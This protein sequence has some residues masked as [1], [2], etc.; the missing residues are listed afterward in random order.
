MAR[1]FGSLGRWG[2]AVAGLLGLGLVGPWAQT[3]QELFPLAVGNRWEYRGMLTQMPEMPTAGLQP[4]GTP[5]GWGPPAFLTLQW[6]GTMVIEVVRPSKEVAAPGEVF[7]VKQERQFVPAT[8]RQ[9]FSLLTVWFASVDKESLKIHALRL[10]AL[11]AE[12]GAAGRLV[13]YEPPHLHLE[14]PFEE[15]RVWRVGPWWWDGLEMTLYARCEGKE[16][17][18]VPA[19]MYRNAI[20]IFYFANDVRGAISFREPM[21]MILKVGSG[22]IHWVEWYVPGVG[23]VKQQF[24]ISHDAAIEGM[25][26]L[27]PFRMVRRQVFE[28]AKPPA[29]AGG[30]R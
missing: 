23:M 1:G 17:V 3:P 6:P 26:N 9:T 14:A 8:L 20:K 13:P 21:P 24:R 19:G 5:G 4:G 11:G 12:P 22:E 28:L 2:V 25:P 15:R 7:E 29:L 18:R 10:P 16:D 27:P 30:R